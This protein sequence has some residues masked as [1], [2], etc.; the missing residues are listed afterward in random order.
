MNLTQW[1]SKH[2]LNITQAAERLG[3]PQP[4]VSRI[5]RGVHLPSGKTIAKLTEKSD[6][7]ITAIDLHKAWLAMQAERAA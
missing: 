4:T 6:G 7:A 2:K 1:R 5:E 3:I